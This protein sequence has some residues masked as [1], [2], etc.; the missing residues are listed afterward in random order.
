M[1][2]GCDRVSKLFLPPIFLNIVSCSL[3]LWEQEEKRKQLTKTSIEIIAQVKGWAFATLH[4][5]RGSIFICKA[6]PFTCKSRLPNRCLMAFRQGVIPSAFAAFTAFMWRTQI[7]KNSCNR[8]SILKDCYRLRGQ[9]RSEHTCP[10]RKI[11][12]EKV[13]LGL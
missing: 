1:T 7:I 12:G 4:C 5:C 10:Q 8:L 3:R 2:T 9:L 6:S 11:L 13:G